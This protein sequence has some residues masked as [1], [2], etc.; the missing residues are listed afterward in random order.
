[1]R[2]SKILHCTECHHEWQG[3][4]KKICDWCGAGGVEIG[5]AYAND[6]T[7][8]LVT[9]ECW[10]ASPISTKTAENKGAVRDDVHS[11]RFR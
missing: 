6:P 9:Y 2:E 1:M 3:N 4:K 11:K 10:T 5:N 8:S 7:S